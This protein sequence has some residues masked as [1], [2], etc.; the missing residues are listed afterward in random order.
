MR[1]ERF[2]QFEAAGVPKG[3]TDMAARI[4]SAIAKR[5]KDGSAEFEEEVADPARYKYPTQKLHF[6][7]EIPSSELGEGKIN[8]YEIEK[9]ELL[10]S[11]DSVQFPEEHKEVNPEQRFAG[12][13]YGPNSTIDRKNFKV[14]FHDEGEINIQVKLLLGAEE[15]E[16]LGEKECRE[17]VSETLALTRT[18]IIST[19]GHELMHSYDIGYIKGEETHADSSRYASYGDVR[20]GLRPIDHF[21]WYLYYTTR[22]ESIVR[23]AEVASGMEAQGIEQSKFY[24]Y[25]TSND[26]FKHLKEIKSWTYEGMK[27]DLMKEIDGLRSK[28]PKEQQE[29]LSDEEIIETLLN[30]TIHALNTSALDT[31]IDKIKVPTIFGMALVDPEDDATE[32]EKE[33]YI[34]AFAKEAMKDLKDPDT[35]FKNKE[36]YMRETSERLIKKLGKLYSLA[37]PAAP[38]PLHDRISNR[39]PNRFKRY[40]DIK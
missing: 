10:L 34:K 20:T 29:S 22:C 6:M 17:K 28:F 4:Y 32:E 27:A 8:D 36:R 3:L 2:R 21:I 12:A 40:S 35:Y 16:K 37:K 9:I 19:L 39:Q 7:M 26:A 5:I 13:G 14:V 33:Q 30:N 38:N 15:G 1:I 11:V 23:N 18:K 31:L 25:L 24:D